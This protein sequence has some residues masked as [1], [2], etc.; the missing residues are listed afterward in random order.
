MNANAADLIDP[1]DSVRRGYDAVAASYAENL[2]DELG[3]KPYERAL[4]GLLA[5]LVGAGARVGDVG[6]GPGHVSAYLRAL[7]L[8][9]VGVDLSPAMV[10]EATRRF[11]GEFRTG[12]MLVPGGLGEPDGAWAGA[13]AAYAIVHSDAAERRAAVAELARAVRPGGHLLVSFHVEDADHPPGSSKHVGDWW[14]HEVDLD[15]RFI[16][17]EAVTGELTTGGFRVL[18]TTVR[19]PGSGEA[20]TRRCHV[21]ARRAG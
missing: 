5:E 3:G 4:Y 8:D 13:V 1:A 18:A 6:C 20:A 15:F 9:A 2:S 10:A 11:G 17:P 7:G 12:S 21:L 14:G 19:E 16:E